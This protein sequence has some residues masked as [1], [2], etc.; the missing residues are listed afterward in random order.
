MKHPKIG[1]RPIVD[2]RCS[3]VREA[4]EART[5]QLAETAA[6]LISSAL[7]YTDGQPV[8]CVISP[9]V[10]GGGSEAA[11]CADY[12]SR[13]DV[14]GTLSVTPCWCYGMET[15]DTNPLTVKA[16]WGINSTEYPGAVYLAAAMSAHAQLGLPAYS[17]YGHDVQEKDDFSVPEDVEE[18]IL[19]FARCAIAV[20]S[21][22]DKA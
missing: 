9:V 2:G 16:V 5:L 12:F 17:I 15:I 6:E 19:R 8:E 20:G 18:K 21:M 3:G 1:I 7:R 10:I 22:R 13:E 4:L 14:V 11:C